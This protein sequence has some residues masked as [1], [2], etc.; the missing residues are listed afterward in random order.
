MEEGK[1]T[2]QLNMFILPPSAFLLTT[3]MPLT[4][5]LSP[6]YRGEGVYGVIALWH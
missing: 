2:F 3:R 5:T 6:E 1:T 4:P